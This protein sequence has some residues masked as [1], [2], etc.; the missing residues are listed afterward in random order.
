MLIKFLSLLIKI[1]QSKEKSGLKT[2]DFS[3]LRVN[4]LFLMKFHCVEFVMNPL[5]VTRK[6]IGLALILDF[7]DRGAINQL[8]L[9]ATGSAR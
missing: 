6:I 8:A 2:K 7:F 4:M 9:S 1:L 5:A 3:P